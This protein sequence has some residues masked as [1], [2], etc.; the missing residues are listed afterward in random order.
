MI[1]PAKHGRGQPTQ[2]QLRIG[3][4]LRHALA[5]IL[6]R[7]ELRDPAVSGMAITVTEVRI[8]PDL[9]HAM[10]FVT[11]LG[12]GHD[13]EVIEGLTR[14]RPFLRRR[15]ADGVRLKF[16]PSLSFRRD[17]TFDQAS[18]IDRLLRSPDVARDL[19]HPPATR[20]DDDGEAGQ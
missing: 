5:A 20:S 8:S 10:F 3:E 4:E 16:M 9:R 14:A 11:T 12:G 19:V 6:E 17:A 13:Q 1:P 7:G 18:A 2:R 15:L